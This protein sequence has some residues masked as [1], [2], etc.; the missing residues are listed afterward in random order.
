MKRR[1]PLRREKPLARGPTR[2]KARKHGSLFPAQRDDA[3]RRAVRGC[4]CILRGRRIGRHM[5][6]H[7][8]PLASGLYGFQHVC[9]GPVDPAHIGP[10]QAV[11]APDRGHILPLCRAAHQF[12]DEHRMS[13]YRA[14][15]YTDHQL[16]SLAREFIPEEIA[17]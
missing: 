10:H 11:G 3:Y 17:P 12:Y 8:R 14:T 1:T 2:L 13:F 6:I 4:P 15:G 16:R 7:D 9:W 5:S